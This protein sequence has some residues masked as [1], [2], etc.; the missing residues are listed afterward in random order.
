MKWSL[1]DYY[2]ELIESLL[3]QKP[4]VPSRT[5]SNAFVDSKTYEPQSAMVTLVKTMGSV[6]TSVRAEI[7]PK[8]SNT[9]FQ[10]AQQLES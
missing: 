8:I 10:I 7:I 1:F 3:Q 2:Q 4:G 6:I 5:E 9:F